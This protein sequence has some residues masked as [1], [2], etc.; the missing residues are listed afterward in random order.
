MEIIQII[1]Y[2]LYG[3]LLFITVGWIYGVRVKPIIYPTILTSIY[4]LITLLIF[5][6]SDTNK[7]H[8]IWVVPIIFISGFFN[9]RLL[10]IPIISVTLKI[11]CDV[12]TEIIRIGIDKDKMYQTQI[13][14]TRELVEDWAER[15]KNK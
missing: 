9:V 8:L 14:N 1:G 10:F 4:F 5:S 6:F 7:I 2:I 13:K 12:Y 15:Q 3:I 11:I